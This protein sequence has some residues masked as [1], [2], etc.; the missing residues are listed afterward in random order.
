MRYASHAAIICLADPIFMLSR[1]Q[2]IENVT[3]A[4]RRKRTIPPCSCHV[5]AAN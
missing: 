3:N 5:V 4:R 2:N 1:A